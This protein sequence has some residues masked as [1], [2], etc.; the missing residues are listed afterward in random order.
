[1][2]IFCCHSEDKHVRLPSVVTKV[3]HPVRSKVG[4]GR[5]ARGHSNKQKEAAADLAVDRFFP[6][7]AGAKF[8]RVAFLL[9]PPSA[10]GPQIFFL[11]PSG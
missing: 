3:E 4:R 10:V 7:K 1:M 9:A 8:L 11:P 6:D 2:A 5:R